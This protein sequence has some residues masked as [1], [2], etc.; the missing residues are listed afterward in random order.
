[1]IKPKIYLASKLFRAP[2]WRLFRTLYLNEFE[3]VSTWHDNL[4]VE[5]DD[6]NCDLACRKGWEGNLEQVVNRCDILLAHGEKDDKLNGTMIEI[7]MAFGL[8]K[9]IYLVGSYPWG[10]WKIL[11]HVQHFN[12]LLE[13]VEAIRKD[14][15]VDQ[16]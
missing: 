5:A 4:T 13:A 3:V 12:N 10:T 16:T 14:V 1:M 9:P 8:S 7:G 6:A 11:D 15:C 2:Q